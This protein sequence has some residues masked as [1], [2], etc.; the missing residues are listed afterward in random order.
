MRI[1]ALTT[2]ADDPRTML[3]CGLATARTNDVSV[4]S[5][6]PLTFYRKVVSPQTPR[7]RLRRP[8]N[9]LK[10]WSLRES[11]GGSG[12]HK[13]LYKNAAELLSLDDV[14]AGVRSS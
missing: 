8:W 12:I 10:K 2:V 6:L 4:I 7:P 11:R 5:A 9:A 13:L 3:S 1:N 14:S